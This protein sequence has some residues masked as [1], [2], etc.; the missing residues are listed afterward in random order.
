MPRIQS[1]VSG[2]S[3]PT[4]KPVTDYHD[5]GPDFDTA[6]RLREGRSR[7]SMHDT[8]DSDSD[9]RNTPRMETADYTWKRAMNLDAPP[10]RPGFAQRWVRAEF[11]SENDNLNWQGKTREGWRPRD[12]ASIPES[13]AYF[14]MGSAMGTS[15]VIRVG[16][17]VLMEIPEHMLRAKRRSITEQTR[18]QEASVSMDTEKIS[19]EG[20]RNGAPPIVREDRV[21]VETGR[22]RPPTLA[23]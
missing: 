12:P 3:Y 5:D 21:D 22:R 13:E 9:G 15:S 20:M 4:P 23:D 14:G 17:L 2:T 19:R 18:R 16:G 7:G 8:R 10:P 6:D 1:H 11:R